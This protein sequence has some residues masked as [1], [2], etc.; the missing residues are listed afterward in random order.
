MIETYISFVNNYHTSQQA[1]RICKEQSSLFS[2]FVEQQAKEHKGKLTLK[3]LIIQ[4]VQRIPRYELYIKDFLKCT[5][6]NH[7]DY[8][9]LTK[10]SKEL[11][12]LAEKI[13]Q[14]HKELHE[15]Y[16][17]DSQSVLQI[18]Q[19]LIENLDDV[20]ILSLKANN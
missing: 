19:D 16:G 11:H 9:L 14:V 20:N 4:P 2:K 18:V 12:N 8:L 13:D 17:T 5:P 3:D 10:A 7:S 1:I 15:S 6:V